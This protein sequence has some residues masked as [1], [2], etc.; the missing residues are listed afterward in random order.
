MAQVD[1]DD[2][3]LNSNQ[4]ITKILLQ[5]IEG[6]AIVLGEAAER[7]G[8]S[9]RTIQR[10]MSVIKNNLLY[11]EHFKFQHNTETEEYYLDIQGTVPFADILAIMKVLI[12]TRVFSKDTLDNISNDL[13]LAVGS[14][15]QEEVRKTMTTIRSSYES[16]TTNDSLLELI[17]KFNDWV[18]DQTTINFLYKNG[19][20]KA[21]PIKMQTGVPLSLYFADHYFYVVMYMVRAGQKDADGRAFVYRLDRFIGKPE[22]LIKRKIQVPREKWEDEDSI[23]AKSYK[24]SS[25][26][27]VNY[28]FIY[29]ENPQIALDQ[30][31]NSKAKRDVNGD[32]YKDKDG[33]TTIEGYLSYNGAKMW[34]IS[35]GSKVRVKAPG[36]LAIDVKNDLQKALDFYDK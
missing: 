20:V 22:P 33:G 9:E 10:D 19:G 30:L 5:M 24:M 27:I 1:N 8:V 26:E 7:Y 3:A 34:A 12:G 15:E 11:S 31:P 23:R 35:Q 13:Q 32:F 28:T 16:V 14:L 2:K 6:D 29:Y 25:G 18:D 21:K 36:K 17:L 4:R